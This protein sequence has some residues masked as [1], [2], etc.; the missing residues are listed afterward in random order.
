MANVEG[1]A[2]QAPTDIATPGGSPGLLASLLSSQW[3]QE[4]AARVGARLAAL[5][6]APLRA[7]TK[8]FVARHAHVTEALLRD[9]EFV[10]APVNAK[11][12]GEVNGPFVLGMDRDA[13]LALERQA[14]YRALGSVD[15]A[16]IRRAVADRAADIVEAANFELDVVGGYARPVAA[17][18]A[19]SLFGIGGP[20]VRTFQDVARAVFAHTF[21][22]LS[23]DKTV[24][25]RALRAA[26][27]MRKWFEAEIER[28]QASAQPGADMMG[29][30]LQNKAIDAD[31]V[32]RTLGGM[33]VG[34]IDTT[35][36]SVAKILSM[37]GKDRI[38]AANLAADLDD[39]NRLAGWCQEALR[40]WPHNPILLRSAATDTTLAGVEVRRGDSVI[41]LTQAAMFDEEAFPDPLVLRPDRPAASYLH[42]GAGLHPCAGRAVNAFQIPLLVGALVRRGIKS[43]GPVEWAGP[44]P[45]RLI[46]KFDR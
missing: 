22:N 42:F 39:E 2:G 36:S 23:D 5:W 12:I 4:T 13:K 27:L 34:S 10:I 16:P 20:D 38:L 18:T 25:A 26:E 1:T 24:R 43:V 9:L 32:R 3:A 29:F 35:A 17:Q 28:R 40:R 45:D 33:L 15:L 30:L 7:G 21:L 11:R 37:I 6:G 41:L 46:V 14:L 31:C 8:V 19:K 44:F